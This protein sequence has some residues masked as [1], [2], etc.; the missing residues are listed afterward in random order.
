MYTCCITD[1]NGTDNHI[2]SC[3]SLFLSN[4]ASWTDSSS[5]LAHEINMQGL[6]LIHIQHLLQLQFKEDDIELAVS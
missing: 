3:Y 1:W 6:L 2:D 4:V 5:L